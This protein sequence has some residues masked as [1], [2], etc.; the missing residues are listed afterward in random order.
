MR[1]VRFCVLTLT[2]VLMTSSL[3]ADYTYSDDHLF[4][5]EKK[6][7]ED[8]P[9]FRV[10]I[11]EEQDWHH[12][13]SVKGEKGATAKFSKFGYDGH[14]IWFLD[15]ITDNSVPSRSVLAYEFEKLYRVV[16]N[17]NLGF[18]FQEI[19]LETKQWKL[20]R[21]FVGQIEQNIV[22]N[23]D[24]ERGLICH[25]EVEGSVGEDKLA[26]PEQVK[27]KRDTRNSYYVHSL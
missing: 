27:G 11:R 23:Y 16:R 3:L 13:Y 15:L 7:S 17:H 4:R 26:T 21:W 10:E 20:N 2:S 22:L 6:G 19:D 8:L 25:T 5:F 14:E 24:D 1:M 18:R 9:K 12:I